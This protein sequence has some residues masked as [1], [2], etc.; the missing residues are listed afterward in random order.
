VSGTAR[1]RPDLYWR[2]E[3]EEA[4]LRRRVVVVVA[5][6]GDVAVGWGR[7]LVGCG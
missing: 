2:E 7:R 4:L 6:F 1:G 5:R 3:E